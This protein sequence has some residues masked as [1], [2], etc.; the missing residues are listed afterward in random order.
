MKKML[1]FKFC[2]F[3]IYIILKNSLIPSEGRSFWMMYYIYLEGECFRDATSAE[4]KTSFAYLEQFSYPLSLSTSSF[5]VEKMRVL[6][7]TKTDLESLINKRMN[8]FF[9]PSKKFFLPKSSF[10]FQKALIHSVKSIDYHD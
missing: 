6:R 9:F 8:G 3:R 7:I 2:V 1:F 4:C 5:F 10:S